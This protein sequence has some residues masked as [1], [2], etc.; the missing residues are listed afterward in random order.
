MTSD[1]TT[2]ESA[3]PA[4]AA[5]CDDPGL[6]D[7]WIDPI[8]NAIRERVRGFIEELIYGELDAVL[9]RRRYVRRPPDS[10]DGATVTGYRHGSRTRTLMGTFGQTEITVPRARLQAAEGGTTEWHSEALRAY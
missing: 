4:A 7:S 6:F 3:Q 5:T 2:I 10:D 1:T 8:E 9:G